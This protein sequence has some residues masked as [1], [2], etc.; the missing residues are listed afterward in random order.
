MQ[1]RYCYQYFVPEVKIQ[2]LERGRN[3]N[4]SQHVMFTFKLDQII[5]IIIIIIIITFIIGVP[6]Y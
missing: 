2:S 6:Q 3:G 4:K 1:N 5:I